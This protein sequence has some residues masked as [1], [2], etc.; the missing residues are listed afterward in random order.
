MENLKLDDLLPLPE[1]EPFTGETLRADGWVYRDFPRMTKDALEKIL[2]II[3]EENIRW[4]TFVN[5]KGKHPETGEVIESVRGQ[6][7]LSP[8]AMEALNAYAARS[9]VPAQPETK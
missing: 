2:A 9:K 3:G 5:Y 4:L 6:C 8:K 7:F 1:G